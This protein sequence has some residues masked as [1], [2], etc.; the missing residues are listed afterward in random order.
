VEVT[1]PKGAV[2]RFFRSVGANRKGINYEKYT[3]ELINNLLNDY[4]EFDMN[5]NMATSDS[6][7]D[8]LGGKSLNQVVSFEGEIT[9]KKSSNQGNLITPFARI[10]RNW[11]GWSISKDEAEKIIVKLNKVFRTSFY[12]DY[13][14]NQTKRIFLYNIG[15]DLYVYEKAIKNM[16]LPTNRQLQ[17][18]FQHHHQ[19]LGYLSKKWTYMIALNKYKKALKKQNYKDMSN[20]IRT[21]LGVAY[22]SLTLEGLEELFGGRENFLIVSRLDGFR[23]GDEDGD[24]PIFSSTVGEI[25]AKS[26]NGP[27][28]KMMDLTGMTQSEFFAYWLLDRLQ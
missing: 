5:L 13:I 4:T 23:E 17:D 16:L 28:M 26:M 3:V 27:L 25:G 11:R 2:R 9:D 1:H 24:K 22:N 6:P 8:S 7:G 20:S 19:K 18:I 21:L 12:P 10:S 14:L 15:V